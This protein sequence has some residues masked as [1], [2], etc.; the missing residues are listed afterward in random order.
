MADVD[1][2]LQSKPSSS[3][4]RH[5]VW[6]SASIAPDYTSQHALVFSIAEHR[7]AIAAD[8]IEQI[9]ELPAI[10]DVPSAGAT[11]LGLANHGGKPV[12]VVDVSPLLSLVSAGPEVFR[13]GV[14]LN[15]KG[16]RVML[17]IEAV[18]VLREL[19][20]ESG[21]TLPAQYQRAGFAESVCDLAIG[22]DSVQH[23]ADHTAYLNTSSEKSNQRV[24][25]LNVPKLLLAVRHAAGSTG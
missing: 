16:L 25:V 11:L 14:L 19:S 5:K 13:H 20:S 18:I 6:D 12:P 3:E 7:F 8:Y 1:L 17:A 2:E 22:I 21:G 24:V 15:Y 10:V 23:T 4:P 9:V